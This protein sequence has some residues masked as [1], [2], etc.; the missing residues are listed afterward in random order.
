[1]TKHA[2]ISR[3]GLFAAAGAAGAAAALGPI[4]ATAAA[5]QMGA[6]APAWRRFTLGGFEVTTLVD[7]TTP[8]EAP[9]KIFG[10][11]QD[12]GT[13]AALLA[14]NF[15]PAEA[16]MFTFNPTVVNTGAEVILFDAGL[17]AGARGGGM[18]RTRDLLAQSGIAPEQVDIVVI[19]HF[20]PDH[21]GGL[22]EA[23]G[24]AFPNARYVTGATEYDFWSAP[25]RMSGPTERVATLTASN[26]VPLAEKM[27]FLSPGDAVVSGVEA[28]AAMGHTPGHLGFHVESE[29]ARVM[30]SAD[31]CNHYVLS[32][33]RPDWQ[34]LFDM[35]KA[36]AAQT[37][38]DLFGMIAA[39]RIPVI[40]YHFPSI[41]FVE[42]HGEG[43]RFVAASYQ[44]DL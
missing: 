11:D 2:T 19:T 27:T 7:G 9:E 28:V 24:P 18:G 39:D 29:G 40:G 30:I 44:L 32:L 26:V 35:D 3:R 5:P 22:M 15:L 16:A 1:M 38:K 33:Q 23:D 41:G 36:M 14:E 25:E 31:A 17:G 43:F 42:P 37:R 21:I 4:A 13:V 12:P 34:V 8:R 6:H 10:T 20:H